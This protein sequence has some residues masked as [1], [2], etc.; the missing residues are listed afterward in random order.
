VSKCT[1][2]ERSEAEDGAASDLLVLLKKLPQE[3]TT[4]VLVNQLV[5]FIEA[6]ERDEPPHFA[7][8]LLAQMDEQQRQREAEALNTRK[9]DAK[10]LQAVRI[11]VQ[12]DAFSSAFKPTAMEKWLKEHSS[13]VNLTGF[14]HHW[15]KGVSYRDTLKT[16]LTQAENA[17]GA[18]CYWNPHTH[19]N[20]M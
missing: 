9:E 8:T 15:R 14:D 18:T 6:T 19:T 11:Q 13:D 10:L 17:R 20:N 16:Y 7:Q 1:Q 3:D 2:I 12:Q 4:P 5:E